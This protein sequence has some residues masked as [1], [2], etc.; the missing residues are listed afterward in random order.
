[1]DGFLSVHLLGN[2]LLVTKVLWEGK[3]ET[4]LVAAIEFISGGKMTRKAKMKTVDTGN[5]EIKSRYEFKIYCLQNARHRFSCY[6]VLL[7]SLAKLL[8]CT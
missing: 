2:G 1:M 8:E 6:D 5:D 7:A 3:K 4:G